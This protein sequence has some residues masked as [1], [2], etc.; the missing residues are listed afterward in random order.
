MR[1]RPF[2]LSGRRRLI[3]LLAVALLGV[4]AAAWSY[5]KAASSGAASGYVGTLA[6]STI[7]SPT[8][9]AGSVTVTWS[10]VT[11]PGS[12]AVSYYVRRDGTAASSACPSSSSPGTQ[13]SCT[14]TGVSVGNHKYTVTAVWRSWTATSAAANAQV[15]TGPATHLLLTP[16]SK[17][18]TAGSADN[19]TLTAQDA[20]NNTVT[21]YAGAKSLVFTGANSSGSLHP[22]VT[23]SGGTPVEFGAAES[24]NFANGVATVSGSSNGAMTLYKAETANVSV[25]DGTLSSTTVAVTV[26]PASVNSFTVPTPSTQTAGGAFSETL[27][28]KDAY[29]NT[30]TGYEGAKTI[31]FSGPANSPSGEAPKYPASVSFTGGV[32]SPG[33]SITLFNASSATLTATQGTII[34]SSGSFAVSAASANKFTVPTPSTQTAGSAFSETLTAKDAYGNTAT[35]YEGAK[36]IAFSGPANSPS[37]EAPKYPASVSFTGGVSSPG[38]SITLFNASSAT[39]TAT[40]GTIIGSSGSFAV[41]PAGANSFTVPTPSTQTA[42]GAFSETL[43]AVDLYGNTATAYTGSQTIAFTGPASSPNGKAPA[44]PTSVSFT[45]GVSS[46]AASIT[47]YDAQTTALTATQGGVSGSSAS[48]TVIAATASSL[49]LAA[50]STSPTAGEADNLTISALDPSG[51]TAVNYSGSKALTFGGAIA[52]GSNHATVSN[53]SGSTVNFGSSTTITFT[54]GAAKVSGSSN[55]V[56]KLYAAEAAKVTVSDGSINNDA[57][58]LAVMVGAGSVSTISVAGPGTQTAGTPFN[59]TITAKDSFGNGVSGAQSLT[60][61]GPASSPN[62]TTPAYPSSVAFTGGEGKATLTLADAQ[63]TAITVAQGSIKGTSTSFTVNPAGASSLSLAATTTTPAA[64]AAD[65][66]TI[67]ALDSFGNTATSYTGSKSLTFGGASTIAGNHPTVSNASGSTVNFGSSTTITFTSGAAKVSGSNNGVMKLYTAEAAK[68]TVSDGSINNGAGLA[69]MVEGVT[70]SSLSLTN[71]NFGG[72]SKGK[73]EKG[74]SLTV[75]FSAPIAVSSLCSAWSGNGSDHELS[76]NNEVTVTVADGPGATDDSLT[77]SSSKCT[78][79]LGT[80]DLGSSGYVSGGNVA[81]AG[82][83]SSRSTVEYTANSDTLEVTLGGSSGAGTT[84]QVSSSVATL[85]PDPA[86]TD[87]FGNGLPSF[88]T[89]STQQF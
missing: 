23:N 15:T 8:P 33:A 24:I 59:L 13:T 87:P 70:I 88:S 62:S 18:Q 29:G 47:L 55:G 14:D 30:A 6:A 66:V 10:A 82:N 1:L 17:T 22:T 36:T 84:K 64:G 72:S 45:G 71:H 12:G 61:S 35:G 85:T 31:A 80:I 20:S 83:G 51:N 38:A 7:S 26:S 9:G 42:G 54:S 63:S 25:S 65:N 76:G 48:F 67:N 32:S 44:Y 75:G 57:S 43:T 3:A 58:P 56:M 34:G 21:T 77:V 74:D 5:W 4:T 46:P 27:T 79:H 37:G 52:I 69:V 39:L 53:A 81:F 40:Q 89:G 73:I 16:A 11:P 19:L 2:T 60:F 28:A 78:F 50:A 41:S 68:V 86:L 49:S